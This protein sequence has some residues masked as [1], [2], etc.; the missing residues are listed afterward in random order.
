NEIKNYEESDKAFEEAL[1]IDSVNI[2]VLNNYSYYLSLR[3]EKLEQA[4]EM[5]KKSNDLDTNNASFQDTYG[6]ILYKMGEFDEAIVWLQKALDNG[7]D[8][9][10]VILEHLGDAQFK[11]GNKNLAIATWIKAKEAGKG[12]DLLE[13][14]ILKKDLV[15]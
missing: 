6:W 13:E 9:N 12:S 4:K 10:A 11:Q 1:K 3:E 5:S 14:K 15:E 8:K 7:G 2:Q